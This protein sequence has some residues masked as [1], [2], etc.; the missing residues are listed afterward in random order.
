[1]LVM[2]VYSL[3]DAVFVFLVFV[4]VR[5]IIVLAALLLSS[6]FCLGELCV[7]F[8][9]VWRLLWFLGSELF[10]AL[11]FVAPSCVYYLWFCCVRLL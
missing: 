4:M 10:Y 11:I 6:V 2:V 5:S 3:F 7:S 1:M 8:V 9:F